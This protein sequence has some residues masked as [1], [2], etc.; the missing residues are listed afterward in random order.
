MSFDFEG[1]FGSAVLAMH[2]RP[3][4]SGRLVSAMPKVGASL[5]VARSK[6]IFMYLCTYV[7]FV[8]ISFFSKKRILS[9]YRY[10]NMDE[11]IAR[12]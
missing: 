8:W 4:R 6:V 10:I 7:F 5:T 3:K 2:E 1:R 12:L 9:V 11:Y